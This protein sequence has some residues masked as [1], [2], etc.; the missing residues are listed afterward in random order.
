MA[1]VKNEAAKAAKELRA[2][3]VAEAAERDKWKAT[4][5]ADEIDRIAAGESIDAMAPDG[6]PSQETGVQK[7]MTG[8]PGAAYQT[9]AATPSKA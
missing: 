4:P 1:E 2:A 5:N 7:T 3:G 8:K 6:S 9:R